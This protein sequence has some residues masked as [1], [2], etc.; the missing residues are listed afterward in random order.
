MNSYTNRTALGAIWG[1]VSRLHVDCWG[2]GSNH[3]HSNHWMATLLPESQPTLQSLEKVQI[4]KA[5]CYIISFKEPFHP[6]IKDT[7]SSVV[8]LLSGA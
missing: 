3:R 6:I 5:E 8:L 7:S 2:Q 4:H 1:S